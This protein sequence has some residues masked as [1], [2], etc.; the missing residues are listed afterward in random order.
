VAQRNGIV[1][2]ILVRLETKDRLVPVRFY[3]YDTGQ[4]ILDRP[5]MRS[6]GVCSF[7]EGAEM[8]HVFV[9][10]ESNG[11]DNDR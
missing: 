8:M 4:V 5:P 6:L 1:V 9:E 3:V 11:S 2:Y 7:F 10:T